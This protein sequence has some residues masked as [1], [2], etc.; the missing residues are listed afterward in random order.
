MQIAILAGGL[1]TR[2]GELSKNEPKSLLKI[3][4][5]PFIEY[6]IDHL[7]R[8]GITDILIC[9]GH[10]GESIER[11]LGQGTR[12]G[13]TIKYSREDR[14]LGTAGA[15]KKAASLLNDT[16]IT[17][18]G[19]SYLCIDFPMIMDYFLAR[20]K[21]A[22]MTVYKNRDR[23]D[24]SNTSISGSLVTGYSK[25]GR[26]KPMVYIDYG[27]HVFR[28]SVLELIPGDRHYP[29]EDLF[30]IL[31]SQRQLLAFEVRQRF[32][33]IGSVAGIRDFT[34]YVKGQR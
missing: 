3:Q 27:A 10:L 5:R 25:N 31:I 32:Y 16:F 24:K 29:L 8:Q 1:A 22:L 7:R 21:L 11:Y 15:L 26:T 19:D 18:Y 17:M 23:H 33:E 14:P 34:E 9:N 4:G 28:K 12:Y 6:Q 2:L 13:V 30:P 20:D